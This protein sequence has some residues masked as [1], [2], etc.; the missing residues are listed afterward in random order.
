MLKKMVTAGTTLAL[1]AGSMAVLTATPAAADPSTA[2]SDPMA[3]AIAAADR[4][5]NAGYDSL[6]LTASDQYERQEVFPWGNGTG[7]YSV[8]YERSYHGLPVIGGDAVVLADGNG[9]VRQVNTATSITIALDT[10][11]SIASDKAVTTS[12]KEQGATQTVESKRLVVHVKDDTQRLAWETVLRG[13]QKNGAPSHLTVWVDA[14]TG[15]VL[16]EREDVSEGSGTGKWNGPSPLTIQTSQQGS[17]YYMRDTTRPGLQ[18]SPYNGSVYSG[19]DDSWGNGTGTSTETGCVDAM[20]GAQTEWNMLR[21]WLGRTSHNGSGGS[22]PVSVGL[23]EQNAYWDGSSVTIG[24]NSAGNWISSMDVVGHEYGHGLDQFTPGGTSSEAGLGEATGDIFGALTEAYANQS[25]TYDEPDYLVG[26]EINLVGTGPIRNMYNPSLVNNDPNCYSA[27]IPNT[28]VHKAAGPL[29]HWFY[30]LAE[31][32]APGGGKPNSPTC[33]S[34]AVTGVTVQTAGKIWMGGMLL[35]TSGMTYKKYRTATL[36]SA[37]NL[38][39]TCGLFNKTKAAWD[40]V[41]V[42]AQPGDP[43]CSGPSQDFTITLSPSSGTI[44]PG[45]SGTATVGTTTIGTAQTINLTTA[46]SGGSGVTASVSP[47]SVTTGNSATLSIAVA[48]GST[49]TR[50]I[51]V[52]GT[53][54]AT[55]SVTYNLTIGG[56]NPNP[57]VPDVSVDNVK[58]HLQQ[59]QTIASNNG[60]NRR[61][62]SAGYTASVAYIKGKLQAAG[63]TVSE[64]NCSSCTYPSNNLIAEWPQGDANNVLMLGA[65]LD[66]VSAGPGINDNGSGSATLLEVALT[67]AAKNP[68]MTGRVRFAWWTDEE[69]G[70]NGSKFYVNNLSSTERSKIKSYLNFDMVGSTNGGYFINNINSAA[71]THLKAYWSTAPLNLSPEE[72]TEGAGRSDDYSFQN[73]GI[74]TSGYAAGASARKTS[75]QA[76]KWGGTANAAYDA[77][78]HSSCDS[79]PSNINTTVLDRSAD[80]V[81]YAIWKTS[82]GTTT[83]TDPDFSISLS[84]SSGS[85]TAGGSVSTTVNTSTVVAPAQ[86]VNLSYTAQAGITVSFNPSSVTSGGSSSATINVPTGTPNNTYTVTITGTGTQFSHSTTYSVTVGGGPGCT[87]GGNKITNGGFESGAS[88]WTGSTGAIG[89]WGSQGQPAHGGTRAAWIDG[90]GY[91]ATDTITQNVTVPAGCSSTSL[92]FWIHIDTDETEAVDYDVLTVSVGGT[93]VQTFSNQD[94]AGG[95][96]QVTVPL[97]SYAGQTVAVRF[98]GVEDASLQTSFVVDDVT[99]TVS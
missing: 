64:Q 74:A 84:S 16:G 52:T 86:T 87:G 30:L 41:S 89:A 22:W 97:G 81:A 60:G 5:V 20:Y 61:A 17:T 57:G 45:Q 55:H 68:T 83:P 10:N 49:G 91:A 56:T 66:S 26:E 80:G 36:T 37:K 25:T 63:Y 50:T 85:T 58:A 21:D 31:G 69:Q 3:N 98:S 13:T 44:D 73:A 65:H 4:A 38:D 9:A 19:P 78:Y 23:N 93:A 76:T 35:K 95:Y 34:Q 72:N 32:S 47:T 54:T 1:F 92:S 99:F 90:Y 28:E 77:C 39:S 24:K 12:K 62:G 14:Q 2:A 71:A 29:N 51:T 88:P 27:S 75:A 40:A 11:P 8:A 67:L 79:Y 43:T 15:K 70:L 42:P 48:A 18:C 59:L 82:V 33:N 46:V 6:T 94:A 7:L 96:V 53:G